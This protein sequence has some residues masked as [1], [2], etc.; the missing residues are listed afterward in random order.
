[1]T[2]GLARSPDH[3]R[4]AVGALIVALMCLGWVAP[5]PSSHPDDHRRAPF[6]AAILD[7]DAATGAAIDSDAD[8]QAVFPG[9]PTAEGATF[10]R[11]RLLRPRS[12]L[13]LGLAPLALAPKTS[14]PRRG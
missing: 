9:G 8:T 13:G 3:R 6:A 14:P 11:R 7:L 12:S 4:R 1:M 2:S 5:S 10:L